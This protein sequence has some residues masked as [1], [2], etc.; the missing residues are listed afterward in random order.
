MTRLC[1]QQQVAYVQTSEHSNT[2]L[3]GLTQVGLTFLLYLVT[4]ARVNVN[5]SGDLTMVRN[6]PRVV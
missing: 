4:R 1:V 6:Q 3:T 5:L 2:G